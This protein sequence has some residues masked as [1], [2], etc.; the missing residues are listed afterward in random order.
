V[1]VEKDSREIVLTT[2]IKK[3]PQSE[4]PSLTSSTSS[5]GGGFNAKDSSKET[6]STGSYRIARI[7]L[8]VETEP[9]LKGPLSFLSCSGFLLLLLSFQDSY[10]M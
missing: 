5:L 6:N 1:R 10:F 7:S 2:T 9:A 3:P 8:I 4:S